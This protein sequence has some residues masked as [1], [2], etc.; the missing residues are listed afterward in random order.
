MGSPRIIGGVRPFAELARRPESVVYKGYQEALERYVL[1]KVV[2]PAGDS[3]ALMQRFAD[4]AR[5]IARLQHPNV[6]A[7][8]DFGR[9]GDASYLVAEFVDGLDVGALLERGALPVELALFILTET[10]RGLRAA[11]EKE[12]LHRDIKPGNI[13]LSYE[14]NVKLADFGMASYAGAGTSEVRGTVGYLAPEQ[15]RGE[16]ASAA[17]DMFALGATAVEMFT[18]RQAFSGRDMGSVFDAILHHDPLESPAAAALDVELKDILRPLLSRYPAGRPAPAA[19]IQALEAYGAASGFVA[20]GRE[21]A[22]FIGDPDA[23]HFQPFVP[24]ELPPPGSGDGAVDAVSAPP[25]SRQRSR[26]ILL[27]A[28]AGA[29]LVLAA[30]AATVRERAE[31]ASLPGAELSDIADAAFVEEPAAGAGTRDE[32][33]PLG[34]EPDES[35]ASASSDPEDAGDGHQPRE[36][37]SPPIRNSREAE[38]EP[39]P[40]AVAAEP[41]SREQPS[42]DPVAPGRLVLVSEPPASVF[43]NGDSVGITPMLSGLELAVGTY[44]V[45]LRHAS[46]PLV[47]NLADVEAGRETRIDISLWDYVGEYTLEIS[48]WAEIFID[49]VRYDTSPLD[50]PLILAPGERRLELRHPELGAYETV[51]HARAREVRTLRFNLH[52]LLSGER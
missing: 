1:L 27:S 16:H 41:A 50:R 2:E 7:V 25:P 23:Y 15:V 46:F 40:A 20:G 43:I 48:P 5:L 34:E 33:D 11:H 37:G 17:S 52:D 39:P 45:E 29:L 18:G 35:P 13:L 22:S 12:I 49:G 47:R 28:V 36:V 32:A 30:L 42:A 14:G 21:L 10:A 9:D 24:L 6:V 38:T 3:A 19:L 51:L 44:T 26:L 8:Y 4:E 31:P